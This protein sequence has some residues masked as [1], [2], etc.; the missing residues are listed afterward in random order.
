MNLLDVRR[1]FIELSGR[2]DLVTSVSDYSV[3]ADSVNANFYI[4][5]G[6]K[7][8]DDRYQ[9]NHA[10]NVDRFDLSAEDF[11]LDVGPVRAIQNVRV[12]RSSDSTTHELLQV[13]LDQFRQTYGWDETI[14]LGDGGL[15]VTYAVGIMR[16]KGI[17][18]PSQV[19]TRIVFGPK[20]DADYTMLVESLAYSPMLAAD[21]DVSFWSLSY[22][23]VLVRAALYMLETFYRNTT[24]ARDHLEVITQELQG[25]DFNV[26]EGDIANVR[27]RT[28]SWQHIIS[29]S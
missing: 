26:V 4:Q 9:F 19:K 11:L 27:F 24:G 6:Q 18:H 28:D 5:A 15:P 8:L 3:D 23:H 22:P 13:D 29:A 10:S 7:F 25:I 17:D 12:L 21:E 16:S 1:L 20:C 2:Y 14:L